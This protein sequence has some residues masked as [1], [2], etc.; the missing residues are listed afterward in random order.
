MGIAFPMEN[1]ESV[2]EYDVI[3]G[4]TV[5][6]TAIPVSGETFNCWDI[7]GVTYRNGMIDVTIPTSVTKAKAV[8]GNSSHTQVRQSSVNTSFQFDNNFI[9]L[10]SAVQGEASIYAADGK[11]TKSLGILG[12]KI[13]IADLPEGN[14]IFVLS[15]G[16]EPTQVAR[17]N[18]K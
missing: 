8:F 16:D 4:S 18:K 2:S 12:D 17:F 9:Y 6:L 3:V 14:Y 15:C 5:R 10:P 1:W 13:G 11:L 7:N